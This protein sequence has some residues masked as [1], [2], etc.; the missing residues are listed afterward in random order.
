MNNLF[1]KI[2]LSVM[3]AIL[4]GSAFAVLPSIRNVSARQRHPWNGKVD[5]EYE[6]VG[7]IMTGLSAESAPGLVILAEDI[8]NGYVYPASK[9]TGDTGIAE[10]VHK[11]VWD[12]DEQGFRIDLRKLKIKI[13][14]RTDTYCVIDV[15]S[16]PNAWSYPVTYC[17]SIPEGGWTDEYKREKIVFRRIEPGVSRFGNYGGTTTNV[18]AYYIGVFEITRG[19]YCRIVPDNGTTDSILSQALTYSDLTYYQSYSQLN[20]LTNILARTGLSCNLPTERQWEYACRGGTVS[21]YNDGSD[22]AQAVNEL[23][24]NGWGLYDMHG[25][26]YEWCSNGSLRKGTSYS[27]VTYFD[28]QKNPSNYQGC[29]GRLVMIPS[30]NPSL[31]MICDGECSILVQVPVPDTIATTGMN[32]PDI[33]AAPD[34][35]GVDDAEEVSI[36]MDGNFLFSTAKY[37]WF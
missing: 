7:D 18:N 36:E 34:W 9:L 5:I 11:V 15:S 26:Y 28:Y 37:A 8:E 10:G 30:E 20:L 17:G 4:T 12:L 14:Y 33:T 24:S 21:K 25:G 6:V 3:T 13:A 29:G 35:F 27:V 22:Y 1:R 19:Q 23:G 2:A 16:G 32:L 31:N